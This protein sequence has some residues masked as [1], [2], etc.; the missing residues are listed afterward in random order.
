MDFLELEDFT[1]C[2]H[3]IYLDAI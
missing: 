1:T 3:I 2:Q